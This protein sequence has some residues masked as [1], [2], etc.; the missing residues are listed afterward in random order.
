M[1][2]NADFIGIE[3]IDDISRICG[4]V[5]GTGVGLDETKFFNCLRFIW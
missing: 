3:I 2:H 4:I 5:K 1:N